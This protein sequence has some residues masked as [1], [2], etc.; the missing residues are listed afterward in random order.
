GVSLL[1]CTFLLMGLSIPFAFREAYLRAATVSGPISN[2]QNLGRV[3]E[4]LLLAGLREDGDRKR[5]ASPEGLR[6]GQ[7]VLLTECVQCH[8]LRTVLA[9]PRTPENWRDTVKRMAERSNLVKPISEA[10][11]WQVISYLVA[12]TPELQKVA[13]QKR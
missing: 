3:R 2:P 12:I 5:L 4:Q 6:A 1:I 9:R 10:Q 7:A 13:G 8:D 11:Q